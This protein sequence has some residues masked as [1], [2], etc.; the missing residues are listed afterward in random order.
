[1]ASERRSCRTLAKVEA[2]SALG[3]ASTPTIVIV[4]G[5]DGGLLDTPGSLLG[6]DNFIVIEDGQIIDSASSA[7]FNS[8]D[9]VFDFI[10]EA[11]RAGLE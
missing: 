5:D 8:W 1:M 10:A 2:A 3:V 6:D 11:T 9:Q 4:I 7:N